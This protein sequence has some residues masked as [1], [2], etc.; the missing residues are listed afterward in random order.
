MHYDEFGLFHENAEEV[1]LLLDRAPTVRRE[2][3]PTPSGPAISAL[4]WGDGP[5]E[6]IFLHGGAQNAHTWD[7]VALAL[8]RPLVALDLPGHG[9]SEWRDDKDYRPQ[10]MASDIA[11]VC[12]TL[13]PDAEVLVGMSLGGL[14][15]VVVVAENP[16]VAPRLAVVDVTPG[17]NRDKAKDIIDFVSGPEQ[18]DSFDEMLERTIQFNPTRSESSLR[19]G[20]LHNA[21]QRDDGKWTWRWD[22]PDPSR[23]VDLEGRFADLWEAVE[24]V[25]G[26]MLLVQGGNSPVVDD[27]DITELRRRQPSVR[28]VVVDGAG[29]SVQGDQPL[30]LASLLTDFVST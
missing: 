13:A 9:H 3:V 19:R 8:D 22:L 4:V 30:E 11:H 10:V 15:A 12:E 21:V 29:H 5:P 20:V 18:F 2:R 28:H 1:G 25:S 26:P 27:D 24:A 16:H 14:T 6:M 23:F 17:V 7:T